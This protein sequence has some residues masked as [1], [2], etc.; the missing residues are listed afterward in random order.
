MG[1]TFSVTNFH[2]I[3]GT[4]TISPETNAVIITGKNSSGKSSFVEPFLSILDRRRELATPKPIRDGEKFCEAEITDT[5]LGIRAKCRWT[6]NDSGTLTLHSL[7]GAAYSRPAEKIAELLGGAIVDLSTFL[8]SDRKKQRDAI[9]ER[10][11][12]PFSLEELAAQKAG[13]EERRL[14]AGRERKRLQGALDSKHDPDPSLPKDLISVADL[15]Q[16][17]SRAEVTNHGGQNLAQTIVDRERGAVLAEQ[18][19]DDARKAV[20]HL[21]REAEEAKDSLVQAR[22]SFEGFQEIPVEPIRAQIESADTINDQIR[23]GRAYWSLSE[24]LDAAIIEHEKL[25]A[26]V[27]RIEGVKT[28][29]LKA[30]EFPHPLMSIDEENVLWDGVPLVQVNSADRLKAA[31]SISIATVGDPDLKLIVVRDGDALDQDSLD[32]LI[33]MAE[34]RGFGIL[35][36]R[37]RPDVSEGLIA[38]IYEVSEGNLATG[39]EEK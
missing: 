34:E 17:L 6:K 30:V 9:L 38:T 23:E 1:K 7:D 5:D 8:G 16:A 32:Q 29:A 25:Q 39:G 13:A 2:G 21:T 20:E 28:A 15:S 36:D 10:V 4:M 37:G 31:L 27:E 14:N 18:K 26:E 3:R 22:D 35:I 19:L 24:E 33:G 12:L 11:E